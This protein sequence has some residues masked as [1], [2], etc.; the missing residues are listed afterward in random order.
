VDASLLRLNTDYVDILF[1]HDME[2]VP[3]EQVLNEAILAL[4]QIKEQGKARFIGVSGLPLCIFEKTLTKTDLDVILSYCHYSLNDSS[5]LGIIPLLEQKQIGLVNTSL[6]R[7]VL[8]I[9]KLIQD[10]TWMCGSCR[11]YRRR[12]ALCKYYFEERCNKEVTAYALDHF[13]RW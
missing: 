7:K 11:G 10:K 2:F 6:L 3:L 5:L 1:L 8:D 9:L 4:V 12:C 13:D